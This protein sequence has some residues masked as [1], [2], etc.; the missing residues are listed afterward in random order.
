[1]TIIH[2]VDRQYNT[3]PFARSWADLDLDVLLVTLLQQLES[4]W[5]RDLLLATDEIKPLHPA[6]FQ[7]VFEADED[8]ET[9]SIFSFHTNSEVLAAADLELVWSEVELVPNRSIVFH[10]HTP[11][12]TTLFWRWL[13][14][15][16][17]LFNR[18]DVHF[19]HWHCIPDAHALTEK[20]VFLIKLAD[21]RKQLLH[22]LS[23]VL[24]HAEEVANELYIP[25]YKL[26]LPLAQ[27]ADIDWDTTH[28]DEMR[29]LLETNDRGKGKL[30]HRVR[31]PI[32]LVDELLTAMERLSIWP[33]AVEQV[34]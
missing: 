16:Q 27:L 11:N 13:T 28:W 17:H 1:M 10:L 24:V 20:E 25:P 6:Y 9:E 30:R 26:A 12:G 15:S 29:S 3:V 31:R 19:I 18:A 33:S 5:N 7:P 4:G 2:I 22:Q 34:A 8:E 14:E 23:T 21:E 32:A